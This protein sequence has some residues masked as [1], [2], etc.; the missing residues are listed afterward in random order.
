MRSIVLLGASGFLGHH[1]L[2]HR[3]KNIRVKAISR[4]NKSDLSNYENVDWHKIDKSIED[5][6]D[7]LLEENDVVVNLVYAS[8][9]GR[10]YNLKFL[11]G[12]INSCQNKQIQRLVHCSTGVV[13][14]RTITRITDEETQC[15]PI[16]DYQKTKYLLEELVTNASSDALDTAI[17]RPT[18]ILGSG[19]EN[20]KKLTLSLIEGTKCKLWVKSFLMG[21]RQMHL[22][23]VN[24]VVNSLD[25]LIHHRKKHHGQIYNI[26]FDHD[27]NNTY[28]SIERI[29]L[30][31]ISRSYRP[32]SI[33]LP[34]FLLSFILSLIGKRDEDIN[35]IYL[36]SKI[37]SL[38][39]K[40]CHNLEQAI[41][42][43]AIHLL[44]EHDNKQIR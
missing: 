13:T 21:N 17:L 2:L 43:F 34:I 24:N 29:L 12:V 40:E 25:A 36:S 16:S 38:D 23:P 22:V 3:Q 26:S 6:L 32:P 19:G 4:K 27:E 14:G 30:K 9:R 28:K 11:E 15:F 18:A 37:N 31:K 35:K 42:E 7:Q 20:L 8:D 44:S 39:Y 33:H 41:E 1:F 5:T 10:D